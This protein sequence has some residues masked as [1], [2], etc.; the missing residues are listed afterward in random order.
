MG[1]AGGFQVLPG[2][3]LLL[4][5]GNRNGKRL[6]PLRLHLKQIP[7]NIKEV[8]LIYDRGLKLCLSY[9]DGI[10]PATPHFSETVAV[11][12]GEIHTITAVSTKQQGIILT[13]RK[14]RSIHRLRNKKL[15]E[16]QRL[17][18]RC[19]K[20]SRQWRKYNKAKQYV[21]SKSEAQLKD[22]LHK[23]TRNFVNWAV[24]EHAKAVIAG[25]PEGV[26]RH[27]RKAKNKKKRR[28]RKVAQKLS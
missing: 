21:L 5:Q 18:S 9:E 22:A 28:S 24:A 3:V 14:L 4:S 11:D 23:I 13:G 20:G 2:G 1:S 15:A 17:M 12:M 25:D 7:I 27:T 16:L 19:Q 26:Q 6:A 10:L 8:E